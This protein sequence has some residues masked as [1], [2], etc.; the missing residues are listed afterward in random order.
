MRPAWH[1]P[2]DNRLRPDRF[3]RGNAQG[4]TFH[5]VILSRSYLTSSKSSHLQA[6]R[7]TSDPTRPSRH[8]HS[9]KR[10]HEAALHSPRY[11]RIPFVPVKMHTPKSVATTL[12][13]IPLD[14]TAYRSCW[15]LERMHGLCWPGFP[16][17]RTWNSCA[18]GS[19]IYRCRYFYQAAQ[20]VSSSVRVSRRRRWIFIVHAITLCTFKI[21]STDMS[22]Y[23]FRAQF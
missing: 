23:S 11:H 15:I 19:S 16:V 4:T 21:T 17:R 13:S 2:S 6:Y 12:H 20:T 14:I 9:G 18:S 1:H 22:L 7:H 5:S 10:C 3:A 8:A